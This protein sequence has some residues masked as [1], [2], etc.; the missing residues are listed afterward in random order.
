MIIALATTF[1]F[2]SPAPEV[3]A[4]GRSCRTQCRVALDK[5]NRQ[6]RN[7]GGLNQCRRQYEACIAGC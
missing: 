7:P 6:A 5:C 3:S 1:T 2:M 4:Q